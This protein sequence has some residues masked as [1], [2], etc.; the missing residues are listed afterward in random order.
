MT[1]SHEPSMDAREPTDGDLETFRDLAEGDEVKF[2]EWP[3]SPLRVLGWEEDS[4]FGE[5]VKVESEGS[6]SYLYEVEGHLWHYDADGEGEAN[7][8]PVENLVLVD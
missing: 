6:K 7:P 1:I 3:V 2:F 8:Y 5:V 4:E